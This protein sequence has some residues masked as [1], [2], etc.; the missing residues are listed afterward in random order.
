MAKR[1]GMIIGG[2]PPGIA[3]ALGVGGGDEPQPEK[4]LNLKEKIQESIDEHV[5]CQ[6]HHQQK[7]DKLNQIMELIDN[8]PILME[9]DK[10]YQEM[11]DIGKDDDDPHGS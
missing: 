6:A 3:E 7:L 11:V 9:F 2:L 5:K 1:R 4:T 10:L 8:S